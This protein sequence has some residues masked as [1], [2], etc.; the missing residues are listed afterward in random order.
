MSTQEPFY[1]EFLRSPLTRCEFEFISTFFRHCG[2]ENIEFFTS[3][4]L[5]EFAEQRKIMLYGDE[6]NEWGI[7]TSKL[8]FQG[9]IE[10]V[11]R[12]PSLRE[13]NHGRKIGLYRRTK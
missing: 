5:R 10:E 4:D 13:S 1:P 7:L 6:S 12:V 11:D 9:I 8:K 2:V 3:D